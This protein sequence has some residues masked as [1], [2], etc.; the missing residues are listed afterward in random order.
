MTEGVVTPGSGTRGKP[1]SVNQEA[2]VIIKCRNK[3]EA[4][5][6]KVDWG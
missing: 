2:R 1:C 3:V 5:K 4:L 6:V